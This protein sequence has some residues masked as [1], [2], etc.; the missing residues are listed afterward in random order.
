[1][2]GG[3]ALE[4]CVRANV[5]VGEVLEPCR[6][7]ARGAAW[8]LLTFPC[9]C[10]EFENNRRHG[11]TRRT[12]ITCYQSNLDGTPVLFL[13]SLRQ[14]ARGRVMMYPLW[15]GRSEAEVGLGGGFS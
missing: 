7:A 9:F 14:L 6:S 8:I 5:A 10:R 1:V 12:I 3:E 13:R 2:A 11:R 15:R 4:P